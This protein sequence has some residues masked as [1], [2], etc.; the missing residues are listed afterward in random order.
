MSNAEVI[1]VL[2]NKIKINA[3][4]T[5]NPLPAG[6]TSV[7]AISYWWRLKSVDIVGNTTGF[8]NAYNFQLVQ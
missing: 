7:T 6:S 8:S 3:I 2:P 5:S 1:S 4:N